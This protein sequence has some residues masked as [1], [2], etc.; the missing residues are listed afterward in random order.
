MTKPDFEKIFASGGTTLPLTDSQFLQGFAYLGENPPTKEE[1]NWLFQQLCL[2]MQWLNQNAGFGRWQADHVYAT[3]EIC[4]S[5]VIGDYRFAECTIGGQSGTAE[6]TWGA[7]GATVTDGGVTWVVKDLRQGTS[8]GKIPALVDVGGGIAGLP[9]VN[10]SLLTDLPT[11]DLSPYLK[12]ADYNADH[13]KSLITNGYQ[14][15]PGGLI[16][17]WGTVINEGNINVEQTIPFNFTFP[18][19]C[20]SVNCNRKGATGVT[21]TGYETVS[22]ITSSNF[23]TVYTTSKYWIAIGY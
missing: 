11:P 17:Q 1:F 18:N 3:G 8:I 21:D 15:F 20:L 4:F 2:K 10:G 22:A 14:K 6:P 9:A 23:K 19:S 5:S 12:S 7:V 13:E 16:I